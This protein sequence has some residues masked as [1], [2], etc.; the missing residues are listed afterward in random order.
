MP[1]APDPPDPPDLP[2]VPDLS[3][4]L[5]RAFYERDALRLARALLGKVL[6]V[7]GAEGVMAA[8]LVEVEAYRGPKDLA[9]HTA[10][11]R[12]TP[13]NEV[14]WGP[15]GHLYVYFVYGMHWC[16]NVVAAAPGRPEAVLLRGAEPLAGLELM[17]ARRF[18]DGGRGA[19]RGA[20]RDADLLRGP[21]NLCRALGIDRA[22]NGADLV[23]G[24][25]AGA[26]GGI[27]IVDAPPVAA[28]AVARTPRIGVEYAGEHAALPWRLFVKGSPGVSGPRTA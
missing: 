27:V 14:M 6:V 10:G 25:S 12:R 7:R 20:R 11:G 8:R 26:T 19:S 22:W 21:A 23:A 9:A 16:A 17:R 3:T 24:S 13:R 1:A 4:P 15:A 18:V 5:P 28:R 2:E